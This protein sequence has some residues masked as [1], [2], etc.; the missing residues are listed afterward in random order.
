MR[1][2]I[3]HLYNHS[4]HILKHLLKRGVVMAQ[5]EQFQEAKTITFPGMV[6]RVYSPVLTKE[7]R[8][9]RI[10]QIHNQ[11]AELLKE[12]EKREYP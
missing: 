6:A 9:A 2:V 3:R 10:K 7:E 1:Q 5:Q 12:V 4:R 11:A 8:A